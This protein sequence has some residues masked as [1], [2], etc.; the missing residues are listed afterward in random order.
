MNILNKVKEISVDFSNVT[1]TTNFGIYKISDW[2]DIPN[3]TIDEIYKYISISLTNN[4][5]DI[6][7]LDS[8]PRDIYFYKEYDLNNIV[9]TKKNYEIR[10]N[11]NNRNVQIRYTFEENQT[12]PTIVTLYLFFLP[13][14]NGNQP[15]P[16]ALGVTN[17]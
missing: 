12:L 13:L 9:V 5:Y 2:I 10:K 15:W 14:E 17:Y 4:R 11:P 3:L 8:N 1:T 7:T 16:I 6:S